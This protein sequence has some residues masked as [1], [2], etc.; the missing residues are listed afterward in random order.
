M[1][2]KREG[3]E[4]NSVSERHRKE[5]PWMWNSVQATESSRLSSPGRGAHAKA[6]GWQRMWCV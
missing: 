2:E 5:M 4:K 6:Q 1:K 3:R